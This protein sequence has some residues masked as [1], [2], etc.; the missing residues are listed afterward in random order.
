M[1]IVGWDEARYDH[2]CLTLSEYFKEI[3]L[4]CIIHYIPISA[5]K[6]LNI[7]EPTSDSK[8]ESDT[9]VSALI[10]L[11]VDF[12]D[13]LNKPLRISVKHIGS[14][15]LGPGFDSPHFTE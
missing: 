12:D 4:N 10:K 15:P 13:L 2:V 9:L 1:D 8:I 11:D 14:S 7:S 5:Y 6:G 3:R